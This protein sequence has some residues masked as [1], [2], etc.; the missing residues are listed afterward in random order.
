MKTKV[1]RWIIF[2]VIVSILPLIF[3]YVSIIFRSRPAT[4]TAVLGNG[5]LL[6]VLWPLCAAAIGE[7]FG[8]DGNPDL[9]VYQVISGGSAT[10]I[11]IVSTLLF[12]FVTNAKVDHASI[13]E[14]M[15]IGTSIGLFVFGIG[16]CFGC[17]YLSEK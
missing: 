1:A 8:S 7:L 16:A 17:V 11:L 12:A 4:L 15:I 14:N 9:A 6:V 2:G 10:V 3:S 13:N 5:E